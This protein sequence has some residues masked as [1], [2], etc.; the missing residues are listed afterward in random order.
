MANRYDWSSLVEAGP[1]EWIL[2]VPVSLIAGTDLSRIR[3]EVIPC[4]ETH[5]REI[6]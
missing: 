1:Q 3:I 4:T 5:I 2:F 6:G